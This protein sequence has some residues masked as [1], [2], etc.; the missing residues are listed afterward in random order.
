MKHNA[1]LDTSFWIN[2][3]RIGLIEYVFTY[4]NLYVCE[5]VEKEILIPI[6]KFLV[7]AEDAIFFRH[8]LDQG[9]VKILNPQKTVKSTFH[10]AED[11]AI[12]LAEEMKMIL[13]I[14]NGSPHEYAK[15]QGF[16]VV[17]SAA[18]IVFL[19]FEG[20]INIT[21]AKAKLA[22]LKGL[23]RESIIEENIRLIEFSGGG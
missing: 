14:D 17:N 15:R 7:L 21:E 11:V 10:N 6:S 22:S 20:K 9:H 2:C 12:T 16:D 13:L 4:F 3:Y 1:S 23:L 5:E 19:A 8:K 18:F